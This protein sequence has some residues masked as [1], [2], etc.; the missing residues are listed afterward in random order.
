MKRFILLIVVSLPLLVACAAANSGASSIGE[1][2]EPTSAVERRLR[3]DT[4]PPTATRLP[5]P[6]PTPTSTPRPAPTPRVTPPPTVTVPRIEIIIAALN[7]RQGPGV[8]FAIV[9]SARAGD[10][11]E[12]VGVN[13]TGDWLQIIRE[14]GDLGWI[15]G[16]GLYARWVSSA[17]MDVPVVT[18]PADPLPAS[19]VPAA[20]SAA[21]S[22]NS[23]SGR[24]VLMNRSGGSL[25]VVDIDG[26]DL[27]RLADGVIDPVVS[28]DG[29]QVAFTRWDGAEF[30]GLHLINIDGTGERPILGDMRQPK[31]PSWSPDG[32]KIVVSFQS[33]GLRDPVEICKSYS[34][35]QE[36]RLPRSRVTITRFKLGDDGRIQLCY[37]PFED[38]QWR[39]RQID[40][41][42]GQFEDLPSDEYSYNPAWDPDKP[43]RVIYDGNKGLVQ[44]DVTNGNRWP[45][46]EDV[47]D[48]GPVFAP[49]GR[50]LAL[51][52]KQHD[53]WEVYTLE[54]ETGARRRLTKP[55]IL[56]DPQYNSAAPAWAPDGAH[57]AFLTDRTGSWE[58]WVMEADGSGQRP[59]LLADIQ[60]V[61][62]IDYQ[63]V[64]ERMLNWI[65]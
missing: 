20:V 60:A 23:L 48:S 46:S 65:E 21:P 54:L 3:P 34:F 53:H 31:S 33:G 15:S 44:V 47:R 43:W 40:V 19:G 63:G 49:D 16:Q 55:P 57:L 17:Q 12:V 10:V 5:P 13:E 45:I 42:T 52:Y 4:T 14:D 56:A 61:L 18:S 24:L 11:L 62:S 26:G 59:L 27:R 1:P 22:N 41:T 29:Q 37:I 38:L 2:V 25:F 7:L 64:N 32:Q 39:L 8:D 36:V 30:G 35:G 51:T 58:I 50:L 6:S 28:P 9:G